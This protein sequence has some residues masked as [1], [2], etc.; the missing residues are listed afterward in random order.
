MKHTL[1]ILLLFVLASCNYP[2]APSD[3]LQ[4]ELVG[5]TQLE[6]D[7]ILLKKFEKGSDFTRA[8][9]S[10]IID[11]N[12]T[13][14]GL[15]N[16]TLKLEYSLGT[17]KLLSKYDYRISIPPTNSIYVITEINEPQKEGR[18]STRKIMCG[19]SIQSCKING[20]ETPLR[21]ERLYL[22]K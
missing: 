13:R 20:T 10:L 14:Y 18:Q 16:D 3:G 22:K 4:M 6:A 11:S 1:F 15:V 21:F 12:I 8:I 19:N 5:F 2:C 9:D 7:T 17:T